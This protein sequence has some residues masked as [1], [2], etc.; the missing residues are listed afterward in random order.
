[1]TFER[2]LSFCKLS[3][4]TF[5]KANQIAALR[6]SC[7]LASGRAATIVQYQL[8]V[9]ALANQNAMWDWHV[10]DCIILA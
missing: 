5:T 10:N 1:V 8:A 4:L 9:L 7:D 6:F 3:I 2:F